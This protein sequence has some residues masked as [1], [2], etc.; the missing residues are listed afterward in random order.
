MAAQATILLTSLAKIEATHWLLLAVSLQTRVETN[1]EERSKSKEPTC[2]L[3][4]R[5]ALLIPLASTSTKHKMP[6]ELAFADAGT[7]DWNYS[8]TFCVYP[9]WRRRLSLSRILAG[10][11]SDYEFYWQV[12]SRDHVA[13]FRSR[14]SPTLSFCNNTR[15]ADGTMM[16]FWN[17]QSSLREN[18]R[19]QLRFVTWAALW[20]TIRDYDSLTCPLPASFAQTLIGSHAAQQEC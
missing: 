15:I 12:H 10:D 16:A 19:V 17:W 3:F 13:L 5:I 2:S 11:R 9:H 14:S 7:T 6:S 4:T 8:K 18:Q 20:N 1:A